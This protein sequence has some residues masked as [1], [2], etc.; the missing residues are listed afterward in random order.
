MRINH[1]VR[2]PFESAEYVAP[3]VRGFGVQVV[4][5]MVEEPHVLTRSRVEAVGPAR[6]EHTARHHRERLIVAQ[7]HVDDQLRRLAQHRVR[8]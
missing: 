6:R 8:G 2:G 3:H 7:G 5:V 1:D 4:Q